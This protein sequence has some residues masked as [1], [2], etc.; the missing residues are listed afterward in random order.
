MLVSS[1]AVNLAM[2]EIVHRVLLQ[3]H[4]YPESYLFFFFF[5][6]LLEFWISKLESSK[7]LVRISLRRSSS[8]PLQCVFSDLKIC[9]GAEKVLENSRKMGK[10]MRLEF[11]VS[12]ADR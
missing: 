1:S 4:R 5:F 8:Y 7:P 12:L 6:F 9:L 2:L 3:N 11:I 10:K